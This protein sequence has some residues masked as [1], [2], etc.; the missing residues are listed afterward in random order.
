MPIF[1]LVCR[2]APTCPNYGKVE[3]VLQHFDAQDP[4]CPECGIQM[5][6]RISAPHVIWTR[7]LAAYGD[8]KKETYE[9]DLRRG[10]HWVARKRSGGGTPENPKFELIRTRQ[11]QIAYCKSE[12]LSDPTDF[13]PNVRVS[14]D[15]KSFSSGV[16]EPG[17]WT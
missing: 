15:G 7:P 3:E 10:G 5:K 11:D 14:Q 17:C 6:R 1:E 9:K 13:S 2:S 4:F 16:G 8:P 12:G